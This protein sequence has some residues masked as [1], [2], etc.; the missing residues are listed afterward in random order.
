MDQLAKGIHGQDITTGPGR[1]DYILG[2]PAGDAKATFAQKT[3]DITPHKVVNFDTALKAMT[4][5]IFPTHAY[6]EQK[7]YLCGYL[8]KPT[9]MKVI[10][11][12]M[13]RI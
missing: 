2:L 13:Q 9:D 4:K 5:H 8:K 10:L 12:F 1:F 3:K 11:K 6:R 7:R